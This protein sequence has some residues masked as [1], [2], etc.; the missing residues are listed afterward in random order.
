MPLCNP[1]VDGRPR[2]HPARRNIPEST[3]PKVFSHSRPCHSCHSFRKE[4]E[5]WSSAGMDKTAR[6]FAGPD[7]T[8]G[9][10]PPCLRGSGGAVRD[11]SPI[12]GGWLC[13]D[14]SAWVTRARVQ[15]RCA[16]NPPTRLSADRCPSRTIRHATRPCHASEGGCA[17]TAALQCLKALPP[18]TA[19]LR[20][21]RDAER[22]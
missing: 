4:P 2:A 13:Y 19:R 8:A 12:R 9:K 14:A 17:V 1:L 3:P 6:T 10:R 22:R 16:V 5:A 7:C 11:S 15:K 18:R 20:D 21:G